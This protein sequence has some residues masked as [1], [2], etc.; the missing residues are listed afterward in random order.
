L[1]NLPN[2]EEVNRT[3]PLLV[4]LFDLEMEAVISF[5]APGNFY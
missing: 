4:L 3:Q 5:E 2:K 1:K